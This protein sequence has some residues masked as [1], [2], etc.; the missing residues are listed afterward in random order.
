VNFPTRWNR[1]IHGNNA[2]IAKQGFKTRTGNG[3]NIF[4]IAIMDDALE[5]MKFLNKINVI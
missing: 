1:I 3:A 5:F 4:V 2:F